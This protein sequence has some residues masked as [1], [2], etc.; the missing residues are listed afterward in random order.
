MSVESTGIGD[1]PNSSVPERIRLFT[2]FGFPAAK[3]DAVGG[4]PG[5]RDDHRVMSVHEFLKP[6]TSRREL[7]G[8]QLAGPG[9]CA[10]DEIGNADAAADQVRPILVRHCVSPIKIT[11]DD[12]GKAQRG[13]KAVARM[14]EMSLRGRSPKSRVDADEKQFRLWSDQVGNRRVSEGL[15]LR[16]GEAHEVTVMLLLMINVRRLGECRT[17]NRVAETMSPVSLSP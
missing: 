12:S 1:D 3:S 8:S 11:I 4:Y 5:D 7:G 15:Q 6:R 2:L 10:V 17:A 16:L 9:S 14:C 13:I